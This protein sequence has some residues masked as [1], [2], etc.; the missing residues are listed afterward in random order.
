MLS[1][2]PFSP[3]FSLKTIRSIDYCRKIHFYRFFL[4]EYVFKQ[5]VAQLR[6]TVIMVIPGELITERTVTHPLFH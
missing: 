2:L 6:I 5:K 3:L 1:K 4:F